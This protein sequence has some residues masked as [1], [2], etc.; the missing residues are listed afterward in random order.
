VI[1]PTIACAATPISTTS[2][3]AYRSPVRPLARRT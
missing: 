1:P 2:E 3:R